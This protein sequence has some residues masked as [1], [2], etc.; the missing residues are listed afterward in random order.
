MTIVVLELT[1]TSISCAQIDYLQ[2]KNADLLSRLHS[3]EERT[4]SALTQTGNLDSR[5][6]ELESELQTVDRLAQRLQIDKESTVKAA[7]REVTEFKAI[8]NS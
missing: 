6:L 3:S 5:N 1:C 7:D 8:I 4:R 2:Q